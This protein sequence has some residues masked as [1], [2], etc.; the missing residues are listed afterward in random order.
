MACRWIN[1]MRYLKL[2]AVAVRCAVLI[3]RLS[4]RLWLLITTTKPGRYAASCANVATTGLGISGIALSLVSM[5]VSI[6]LT[7]W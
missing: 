6:S 7:I 5:P 3:R 2:K 1:T 4:K